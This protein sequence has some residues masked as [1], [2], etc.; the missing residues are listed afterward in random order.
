M[1]LK[2][3][4]QDEHIAMVAL[5]PA[6]GVA[7]TRDL[8]QLLPGVNEVTEN[9]WKCMKPNIK[10]EL[11]RGEITILA[12]KVTGK[13]KKTVKATD[14]KEMPVN[15]AVTYI[16]DCMNQETLNKW[17]REETRDEVLAAITKRMDKLGFDKPDAETIDSSTASPM[18][19]NEL[20]SDE[21]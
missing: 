11:D 3:S 20:E 12:Q 6:E 14:L 21:E 16:K 8:V 4:P 9:E 13:D 17:F 15:V 18:S 19:L 5:T 10:A 2:F 1:L 7:I